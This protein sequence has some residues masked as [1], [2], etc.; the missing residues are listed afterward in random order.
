MVDDVNKIL[1]KIMLNIVINNENY[2]KKLI[3]VKKPDGILR[4]IQE[5]H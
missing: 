1:P 4:F 2:V 3:S 5:F